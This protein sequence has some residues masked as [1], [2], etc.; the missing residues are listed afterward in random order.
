MPENNARYLLENLNVMVIDDNKYMATLVI[1]I[2]TAL[3]IK[4]AVEVS[5]AAK[6]FQD[7]I[8]TSIN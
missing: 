8:P 7:L 6:A 1:E 3:G 2:L 5:D 4:N